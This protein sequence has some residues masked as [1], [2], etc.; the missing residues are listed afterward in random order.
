VDDEL[1]ERVKVARL[2]GWATAAVLIMA[3][4]GV[5][6]FAARDE[7]P[8]GRV[9]TAAGQNADGVEVPTTVAEVVPPTLAP[10]TVPPSTTATTVRKPT[11]TAPTTTQ[12]PRPTTTKAPVA[13]TTSTTAAASGINVSMVNSSPVAVTLT[14]NGKTY[15]LA[16]GQQVGPV[17]TTH[18]ANGYDSIAL[19][20]DAVPTCGMGDAD[21]YF[22]KPGNYRLTVETSPG[23]CYPPSGRI[24]S[25]RFRVALA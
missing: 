24:D 10:T 19:T 4:I 6:A 22:P 16:P 2:V 25:V 12:P 7:G 17:A 23:S 8:D 13:S 18:D 15:K 11:T 1:R 21:M 20:H 14:L 5:G 9:V 3:A